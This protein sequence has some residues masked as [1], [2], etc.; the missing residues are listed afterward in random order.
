MSQSFVLFTAFWLVMALIAIGAVWFFERT[1]GGDEDG[2]ESE[3]AA[4]GE[5]GRPLLEVRR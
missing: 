2:D 4:S 5:E 3:T 1:E